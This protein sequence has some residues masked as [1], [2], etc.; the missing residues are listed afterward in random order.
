[1]PADNVRFARMLRTNATRPERN[2][3]HALSR[4]RPRFT[5]QLPIGPYVADFACRRARVIVEIDGSQH[6]D[7]NYDAVRTAAL[8]AQGWRVFRYWNNDVLENIEG[9]VEAILASASLRLPE[10]ERFEAAPSR[11]GRERK[12]REEGP[13]PAPPARAGGESF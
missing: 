6:A 9:V 10:G 7:S 8:E 12:N 11:V 3:W 13:P 2:L 4:Y 5:R 1:M